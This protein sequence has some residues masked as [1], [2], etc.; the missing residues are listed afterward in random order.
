MITFIK[1]SIVLV[2]IIFLMKTAWN[3]V[4]SLIK[5]WYKIFLIPALLLLVYLVLAKG[6]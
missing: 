6:C 4:K 3:V 2:L 5:F 1:I